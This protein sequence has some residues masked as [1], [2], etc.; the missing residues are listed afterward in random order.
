MAS[1][2]DGSV[3][4][5]G[6]TAKA[7]GSSRAEAGVA[8]ATPE[9]RAEKPVVPEEQAVLPKASIGLVGHAVHPWGPPVVPPATVEEDEVEE[10]EREES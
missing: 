3:M 5:P 6:A 1:T 9:A 4:V 2:V 7:A 10:I 8:E